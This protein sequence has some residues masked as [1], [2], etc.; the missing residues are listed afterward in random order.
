MSKFAGALG[1]L[2]L[3]ALATSAHA[4][5]VVDATRIRLTTAGGVVLQVGELVALNFLGTN[6][7]LATEGATATTNQIY[8]DVN[9]GANT[10]P[11]NANDGALPYFR[12]YGDVPTFY[13]A[14]NTSGFLDITFDAPAT[15]ASLSVF[16]RT[17]CCSDRDVYNVEVFNASNVSIFSGQLD[18]RN[19]GHVGTIVFDRPTAAVPEPAAWALMIVGF[20]AAGAVVR[21]RKAALA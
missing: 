21:R 7:A 16:G 15:L 6:V 14:L 11:Q 3:T 5:T 12:S 2:A 20:G 10:G 1:A 9:G 19:D 4:A 13:H 18:A 17:D 8:S